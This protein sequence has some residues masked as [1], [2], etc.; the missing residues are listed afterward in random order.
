MKIVAHSVWLVAVIIATGDVQHVRA[1]DWPNFRGPNHDGIVRG[2]GIKPERDEPLELVWERD[3]GSGFSSFACVGDRTYTAG[4][5]DGRQV[6]YCLDSAN[7]NVVWKRPFEKQYE[8]AQGA[9][10]PRATPTVDDGRVYMLGAHGKLLCCDAKTGDEIWSQQFSHTPQWGYSGSILIEGE[11]A[12]ASAGR[13]D[14]SLVAFDKKTG[15]R[16]WGVGKDPVGYATPYTFT[17]GGKRYIAGFLGDS[18]L[19]A[20]A[21]TGREVWRMGWETDWYVNAAAPIFSDGHLFFSSGYQHGCILLKLTASGDRLES[22]IVWQS[23]VLRNKFQSCVLANGHLY[24]SDDTALKCVEFLTGKSRWTEPRAK[25][26]T[27]VLVDDHLLFLNQSG[28]LQIAAATPDGFDPLTTAEIL[29][30][31]CWT[32]S[33]VH[34]G[35]LYARNLTRL[36]CFDLAG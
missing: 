26:G 34:D 9:N 15:R 10:G 12:I 35:K 36:V 31:R 23:K 33:V 7:G 8:D 22:E 5:A 11:L 20:D 3:V 13:S 6:L 17:F 27:V 28:R 30:G 32:V 24:A 1:A 21:K 4:S 2:A 16:A 18:A 19:I 29:T 14:G 25:H